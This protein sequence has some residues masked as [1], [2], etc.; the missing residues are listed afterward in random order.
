MPSYSTKDGDVLDDICY[1]YYGASS[2]YTEAVLAAN[3]ILLKHDLILPSGI[4]IELPDLPNIE[5]SQETI[6]LFS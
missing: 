6:R 2:E 3:P 5:E 4:T 1:R